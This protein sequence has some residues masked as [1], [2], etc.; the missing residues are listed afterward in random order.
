MTNRVHLTLTVTL[1]LGL[2]S[3]P[4]LAAQQKGQYLT[5]Q[6]GLNAG[7]VPNPGFTYE[8]LARNYSASQLNTSAGQ[9]F[10]QITGKYSFWLD[11]NIFMYVPKYK[12]FHGY[13]AP[14]VAVN[15][16][17]GSVVADFPP[18][19]GL[20]LDGQA[21]GSGLSDTWIE[22]VNFGWHFDRADMQ[23]GYA[24][25]A[26]T[27]RYKPGANNNVGSGYWGNNVN[28][29]FTGYLTKN[30]GTSANAYFD[31]EGHT[32]KTGTQITPGSAVTLEW[33]LG[34]ALPLSEEHD[35]VG[36]VGFVG[37][38]QWQVSDNGGVIGGFGGIPASQIPHYS[39]HSLG[40]QTNLIMDRLGLIGFF[41]YYDEYKAGASLEGRTFV[42]GLTWTYG[43]PKKSN[44]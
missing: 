24:F 6:F 41:K 18:L 38:D 12:N 33:G 30:K 11:E 15:W 4:R 7:I 23:L 8:N 3:A 27:G 34:Q 43:I 1:V 39:V 17:S 31:Y 35:I 29:G 42:F 9:A 16:A 5:G 32:R 28:A 26:P 13:F 40:V 20:N 19:A 44:P 10:P 22:P 2:L 36:Q 14:Y 37:Y 21:G 25:V